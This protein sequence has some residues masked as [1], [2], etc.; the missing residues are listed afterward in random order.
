ML[1]AAGRWGK[2]VKTGQGW[3]V[4]AVHD[5]GLPGTVAVGFPDGWEKGPLTFL[6]SKQPLPSPGV[7]EG[8]GTRDSAAL[9]LTH[10]AET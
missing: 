6:I 8:R 7:W 10:C 4:P 5:L 2:A 3:R 1:E 9:S